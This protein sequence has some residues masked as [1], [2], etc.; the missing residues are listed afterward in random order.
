MMRRRR[1]RDET[2][3]SI[4]SST[5]HP[6]SH[7]PHHRSSS[8]SSCCRCGVGGDG[9]RRGGTTSASSGQGCRREGCSLRHHPLST[10]RSCIHSRRHRHLRVIASLSLSLSLPLWCGVSVYSSAAAG[11]RR[12]GK[13]EMA[14]NTYFFGCLAKFTQASLHVTRHRSFHASF[15]AAIAAC[16]TTSRK[17]HPFLPPPTHKPIQDGQRDA[18]GNLR[19]QGRPRAGTCELPFTRRKPSPRFWFFG[20][21]FARKKWL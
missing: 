15:A 12:G 17:T 6:R 1:R 2:A 13:R 16:S 19:R 14:G 21:A 9:G 10:L 3:D 5:S 11:A 18:E 7:H 20:F 8:S 4:T